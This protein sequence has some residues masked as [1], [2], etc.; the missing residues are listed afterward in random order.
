[1]LLKVFAGRADK[2]SVDLSSIAL[3]GVQQADLQLQ[4]AGSALAGVGSNSA[5]AAGDDVVDISA[6]A[7]ALN[8]AKTQYAASIDVLKLAEQISNATLDVLA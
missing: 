5:N 6:A 1:M 3:A 8:S 2:L 7:V 4:S